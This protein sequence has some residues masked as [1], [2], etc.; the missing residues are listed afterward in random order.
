MS[1]SFWWDDTDFQKNVMTASDPGSD[2]PKLSLP[3]IY[4]DSGTAEPK[5]TSLYAS[6]VYD[7]CVGDG[8]EE[9]VEVFKYEDIGGEHSESSWGPRFHVPIE[10]LYPPNTV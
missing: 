10:H 5:T 3:H 1:S 4:V 8:F 2:Q 9:N 6:Q 7:I